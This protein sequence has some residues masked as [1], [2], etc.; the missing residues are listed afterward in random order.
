MT[1][2]A[3]HCSLALLACAAALVGGRGLR[4]AILSAP[5]HDAVGA[6]PVLPAAGGAAWRNRPRFAAIRPRPSRS[7]SWRRRLAASR[8]SSIALTQQSRRQGCEASGFFQIFGGGGRSEQCGPLNNQISQDRANLAR[9]QNDLQRL[10]SAGANYERDGQRRAVLAALVQNDC[11]PQYRAQAAQ[12]RNL[13]ETLFGSGSVPGQPIKPIVERRRRLRAIARSACAPATAISSRSRFRPRRTVSATTRRPAS[14]CVRLPKCML[15]S[16]RNPGEDMRQAVSANGGKLYTELPT[17][18]KYKT[19][20]SNA[21]VCKQA[22]ES[23]ANAVK[24]DPATQT[25]LERNDIVYRRSE[26]KFCRHRVMPRAVRSCRRRKRVP[27]KGCSRSRRLSPRSLRRLRPISPRAR[28]SRSA[29][30]A[31]NSC[32]N[33]W[34]TCRPRERAPSPAGDAHVTRHRGAAMAA[35][36]HEIMAFRLA[37]DRGL[38]R[39]VQ[40]IVGFR[41]AQAARADRRRLPGRDT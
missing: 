4:P 1:K 32:R 41:S 12:S 36:D 6:R 22:N 17:A 25:A 13:F 15:Y 27:K 30:S 18:F 23:W 37:R 29:R 31:R 7:A 10:Q 8:P 38:D 35:I 16:H 40:E 39:R 28:K 26:P 20:W 34:K 33:N 19:E 9:V 2:I 11:G 21:C 14:A 3:R 5:R 24:D